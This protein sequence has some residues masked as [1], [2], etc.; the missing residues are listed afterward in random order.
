MSDDEFF[1]L[2]ARLGEMQADGTLDEESLSELYTEAA[3]YEDLEQFAEPFLMAAMSLGIDPETL[4]QPI[5][6]PQKEA[7]DEEYEQPVEAEQP[8]LQEHDMDIPEEPETVLVIVRVVDEN[9]NWQEDNQGPR[10]LVPTGCDKPVFLNPYITK[11]SLR[12][13]LPRDRAEEANLYATYQTNLWMSR[14]TIMKRLDQGLQ[15]EDET[16]NMED[17]TPLILARAG[18][19]D[20]NSAAAQVGQTEGNGGGGQ[21]PGQGEQQ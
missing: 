16:D 7:E 11:V 10:M 12:S 5:P 17:D 3:Q 2:L 15:Y 14:K 18:T 20:P 13:A 4:G 21:Q 6:A 1:A 9:G 19:A 8:Q